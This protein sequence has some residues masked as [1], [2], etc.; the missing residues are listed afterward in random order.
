[1]NTKYRRLLFLLLCFTETWAF[2]MQGIGRQTSKPLSM[3]R[4]IDL[5]ECLIFYG[6]S[7]LDEEDDGLHSLIQECKETGAAL[8]S[9]STNGET[10]S[11]SFPDVTFLS[12]TREAPNPVDLW[13]A[14][15]SVVIQP[16]PFGGSAGFGTKLP[17]PERHPMPSRTVVFCETV[18]Q[19][20]AA[21][22]CGM[23]VICFTDNDLADAIVDTFDFYLDDIA[24]PGSFWLNPPHPRDDEGNKV[25]VDDLILEFETAGNEDKPKPD[26]ES[27]AS[28]DMD[29]DELKRILADMAPLR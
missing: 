6:D 26:T 13:E 8:L 1:M 11:K 19:T 5:S 23:R 7:V 15:Q 21:R 17:D 2:I 18:E 4:N 14:I 28:D 27:K 22:S 24:T 9:I 29:D 25:Y 16:H 10:K 12:P 20:R 3:V